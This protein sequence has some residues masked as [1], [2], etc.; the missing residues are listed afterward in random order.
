M[1]S[2]VEAAPAKLDLSIG[3]AKKGK[4]GKK[5]KKTK[6]AMPDPVSR[7]PSVSSEIVPQIPASI[8]A[9]EAARTEN[10]D[11][12]LHQ[13]QHPD[14]ESSRICASR[15]THLFIDE[16]WKKCQKCRALIRHLSLQLARNMN[17]ED[18]NEYEI[19]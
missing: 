9:E 3:K 15:A 16:E 5:G 12:D 6:S 13:Q 4:K 19:I 1:S 14:D 8:T 18:Q 17:E 11:V 10:G 2:E 7:P